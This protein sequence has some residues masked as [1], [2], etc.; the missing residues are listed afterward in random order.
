LTG[1]ARGGTSEVLPRAPRG[2][3]SRLVEP[4]DRRAEITAAV[5]PS[6][7]E[8]EYIERKSEEKH[9]YLRG[10]VVAMAGASTRHNLIAANLIAA[11]RV[12]ARGGPCRVLTGDQRI[13]VESTGLYTYPDV[14]VVCGKMRFHPEHPDTLLNPKLIGAPVENR[15]QEVGEHDQA[16]GDV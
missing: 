4:T 12:S 14:T 10:S 11:L 15:H 9:E 8:G 6:F 16:I 3:P 1:L 13:H 7:T 2:R 5:L